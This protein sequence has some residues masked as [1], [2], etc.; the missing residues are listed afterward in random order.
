MKVT[1]E[2]FEKKYVLVGHHV[3]GAKTAVQRFSGI[4]NIEIPRWC[5]SQEDSKGVPL[6][7]R[8]VGKLCDSKA[9]VTKSSGVESKGFMHSVSHAR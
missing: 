6:N 7:L 4:L 8:P 5:P 3:A 2:S 1:R 9:K